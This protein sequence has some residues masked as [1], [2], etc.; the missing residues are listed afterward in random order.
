M[1]SE[2]KSGVSQQPIKSML[3]HG[4][5]QSLSATLIAFALHPWTLV[6]VNWYLKRSL[7]SLLHDTIARCLLLP[8][9]LLLDTCDAAVFSLFIEHFGF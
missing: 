8:Q 5:L 4:F 6:G 7:P 1:P 3:F 9:P 2:E